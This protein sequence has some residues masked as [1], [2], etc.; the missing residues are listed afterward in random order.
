MGCV[1]SESTE[2]KAFSPMTCSFHSPQ[3]SPLHPAFV[4]YTQQYA[5]E[6]TACTVPAKAGGR[7]SPVSWQQSS[8]EPSIVLMSTK[9]EANASLPIIIQKLGCFTFFKNVAVISIIS[10]LCTPNLTIHYKQYRYITT[11]L[12][13]NKK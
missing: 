7:V 6:H 5:Y 9:D 2:E 11:T 13:N 10:I 1:P 3:A 4:Y 8:L 12:T